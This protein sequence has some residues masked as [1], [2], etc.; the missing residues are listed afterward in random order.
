MTDQIVDLTEG[1]MPGPQGV[2]GPRGP[3]GL[4][5]VNAVPADT[6]VAGYI[7]AD[8]S[9]TWAALAAHDEYRIIMLGDSWTQYYDQLLSKT[10]QSR[11]PAS[12]VKNYGVHGAGI[13]SITNNQIPLAKADSTARHPTHIVVVA[14]IN[15]ILHTQGSYE[16]MTDN[17]SAMVSAIR[18]AWPGVPIHFYPD[19]ARC[20]NTGH[21]SLY[22]ALLLNLTAWGVSVHAESLWMPMRSDFAAYRTDDP[23]PIQNIAHLTRAGYTDLAGLIA[24]GLRGQTI[25]DLCSVGYNVTLYPFGEDDFPAA[26]TPQD[27]TLLAA[28]KQCRMLVASG[29]VSMSLELSGLTTAGS[30]AKTMRYLNMRL[31]TP[32]ELN[33]D[34]S[35]AYQ[36]AT[37]YNPFPPASTVYGD[38]LVADS[39]NVPVYGGTIRTWRAAAQGATAM[40]IVV[41]KGDT[42]SAWRPFSKILTTQ[43]WPLKLG[44]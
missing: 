33:A 43:T 38:L 11:L 5:G 22:E 41:D 18:A 17:S 3:Q 42:T 19:M 7:G 28:S 8:E 1:V 14:G 24:A 13:R 30:L 36:T 26:E 4:P 12:W 21:N 2:Q 6:A 37:R 16:D 23:D 20:P 9:E 34:G 44:N 29:M 31:I 27:N 10:L 15:G 25:A 35:A 40:E 32:R 39:Q